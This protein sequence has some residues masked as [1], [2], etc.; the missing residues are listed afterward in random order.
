MN[1]E[2]SPL[3]Q[4]NSSHWLNSPINKIDL[5]RKFKRT[6]PYQKELLINQ[7][8]IHKKKI[9]EVYQSFISF[10]HF[11]NLN[12]LAF[13]LR[14]SSK[15]IIPQRKLSFLLIIRKKKKGLGLKDAHFVQ[16]LKQ[17][18]IQVVPL[19]PWWEERQLKGEQKGLRNYLNNFS[20][21]L[22]NAGSYVEKFLLI[23]DIEQKLRNFSCS[24]FFELEGDNAIFW[25]QQ[26][27]ESFD[28]NGFSHAN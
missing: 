5:H 12:Y 17:L 25:F 15:S 27:T 6:T 2:S 1:L 9:K 10:P 23:K 3:E 22:E 21:S 18:L 26:Q 13:R 8:F 4:S 19:F 7:F 20:C 11:Y 24:Y 14:K 16:F 28:G